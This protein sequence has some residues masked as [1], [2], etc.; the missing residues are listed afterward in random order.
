MT[1]ADR[2]SIRPLSMFLR[3]MSHFK[4]QSAAFVCAEALWPGLAVVRRSKRH[5]VV[6]DAPPN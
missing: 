1:G 5:D 3:K 2:E 4:G 6:A